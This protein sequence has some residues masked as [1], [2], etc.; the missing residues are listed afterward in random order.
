MKKSILSLGLAVAILGSA[1]QQFE[2]GEGG[3]EYK[4]VKDN[5]KPKAQTGDL[6]SVNM[7]VTT[8]RDSLLSS[9]YT[10]GMPQLINI[11]A[12]SMPGISPADY[13]SMSRLQGEGE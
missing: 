5:G 10:I 13:N 3:L 11:A 9:T 6:L 12:D 7:T 8:D 4:I 1:C 2:K